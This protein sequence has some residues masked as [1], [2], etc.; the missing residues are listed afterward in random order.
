MLKRLMITL[1]FMGVCLSARSA[2]CIA[3]SNVSIN[4]EPRVIT[5]GADYNG[6]QIVVKGSIPMDA[7]VVVQVKG[8]GH[9]TEFLKKGHVLGVLWMNTGSVTFHNLPQVYMIYL[10]ESISISQLSSD[11]QLRQLK[12]GFVSLERNTAITPEEKGERGF[13]FQE[14]FKLKTTE[15]LY[16]EQEKAVT[17][18]PA[19]DGM[20]AFTCAINIP[21]KIKPGSYTITTSLLKNKTLFHSEESPIKITEIGFP[22]FITGLA[23]QHGTLYGVLA[24]LIAIIAGLLM[25]VLFKGGKGGH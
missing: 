7:E 6:A 8:D 15:G 9:D 20:K 11:P 21:C 14:L 3:N 24:T 17:Y 12:T 1:I 18:Q 22:A 4:I 19:N 13:L 23:F 25:G 10:P 5:I 16:V 2:P